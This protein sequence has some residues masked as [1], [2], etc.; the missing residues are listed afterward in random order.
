MSTLRATDV[1]TDELLDFIAG[2]VPGNPSGESLGNYNAVIGNANAADDLGQKTLA[3]IYE[4]QTSLIAAGQPSDAVG[5]YQII[6]STLRGLQRKLGLQ[7]SELF[8]PALQDKFAVELLKGRGYSR[9]W[10]GGLSDQDFAH[11]LSL[12]W[13]SLPDPENGGKSHYDGVGPNHAGTT[14]DAVYVMLKKA[15]DLI[16]RSTPGSESSNSDTATLEPPAP[17][18]ASQ[19]PPSSPEPAPQA[20]ISGGAGLAIGGG[21]AVVGSL[22][23]KFV[24]GVLLSIFTGA[25]LPVMD[26]PTAA[27]FAGIAALVVGWLAHRGGVKIEI[28]KIGVKK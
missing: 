25:P 2:G 22:P 23:I 14:L 1:A 19:Q 18:P 12:E 13:A 6:K 8:T 11:N 20:P 21:T 4:L 24:W 26:D 3:Q 5:R 7:D 27:A 17:Q 10:N 9:W 28:K 15:R 16:G